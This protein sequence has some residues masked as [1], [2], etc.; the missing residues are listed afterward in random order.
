LADKTVLGSKMAR[1]RN[2][3]KDGILPELDDKDGGFGEAIM[4]ML[5]SY[6]ACFRS[7]AHAR[8]YSAVPLNLEIDA[9]IQSN[10]G[11]I[12][13]PNLNLK[14]VSCTH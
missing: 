11:L 13:V 12:P 6:H 3:N 8:V 10:M 1:S 14:S 7:H 4:R 9:K 5:S 2:A